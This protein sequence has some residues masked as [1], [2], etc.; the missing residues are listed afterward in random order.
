MA[1]GDGV[2][3]LSE[4]IATLPPHIIARIET[5]V[6]VLKAVGIA[7]V[8]Y[9]IYVFVMGFINYKRIRRQRA[10]EKKLIEIDKKLDILLKKDKKKDKKK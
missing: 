9:V 8:V 7:F 1:I 5:L 10:M 4:I 2:L 6:V 3:N